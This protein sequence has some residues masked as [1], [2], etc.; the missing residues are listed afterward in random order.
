VRKS[1]A[2]SRA[3]A[4]ATAPPVAPPVPVG[5]QRY[6][7]YYKVLMLCHS[8]CSVQF[9]TL[10]P[11]TFE[12]VRNCSSPSTRSIFRQERRER[13]FTRNRRCLPLNSTREVFDESKARCALKRKPFLQSRILPFQYCKLDTAAMI[14]VWLH[15]ERR[16]DGASASQSYAR[17]G[18]AGSS[19]SACNGCA[20]GRNAGKSR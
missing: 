15:W 17:A 18:G 4:R 3:K 10:F 1:L 16:T 5:L 20:G 2:P 7:S 8:V 11:N 12:I 19:K 9:S 6:V 13:N 14:I